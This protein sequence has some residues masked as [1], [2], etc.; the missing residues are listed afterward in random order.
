VIVPTDIHEGVKK[1]APVG[2]FII[3]SPG[4]DKYLSLLWGK[5]FSVTEVRKKIKIVRRTLVPGAIRAEVYDENGAIVPVENFTLVFCIGYFCR[6][7]WRSSRITSS[8]KFKWF[9]VNLKKG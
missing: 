9:R 2:R 1:R 8:E 4:Y 6:V 5:D 3:V 7:C